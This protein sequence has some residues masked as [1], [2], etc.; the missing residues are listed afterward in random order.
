ML[1][2]S[3]RPWLLQSVRMMTTTKA[4]VGRVWV[5]VLGGLSRQSSNRTGEARVARACAHSKLSPQA[6]SGAI[7]RPNARTPSIKEDQE[8]GNN[9]GGV[10]RIHPHQSF[11]PFSR[12]ALPWNARRM[13]FGERDDILGLLS[14][15]MPAMR[16]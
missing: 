1:P 5:C 3:W 7:D 6:G 9:D 16:A 13:H 11:F 14:G 2:S 8:E 12:L 4:T 10:L 15:Y